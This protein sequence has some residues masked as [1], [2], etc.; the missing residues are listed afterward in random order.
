MKKLL[1]TSDGLTSKKIK[2]E[3]LKLLDKPVSENKVLLMHTAN[4]RRLRIVRKIIRGLMTLGIKKKNI[5]LVNI[6]HK[7]S[8]IPQFDVFYSLG[9]NTFYILYR[10]RKTGFDKVIKRAVKQ[11]KPYI[12]LSAGSIIAHKTIEISGWGK[13]KDINEIGLRSLRGLNLTN[14]AIFPHF[15]KRLKKEVNEFKKKVKYPIV[16][17]KDRQAILIIGN[18]FKKII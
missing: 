2:K 10:A 17:L 4:I 13:E 15:R 7:I 6:R 12:G 5:Y 16:E 8:R 14:I 3:F 11:G 1:L 9:G 18:K